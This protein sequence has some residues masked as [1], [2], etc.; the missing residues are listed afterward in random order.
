[1][2]MR[3]TLRIIALVA[4]AVM[5]LPLPAAGQVFTKYIDNDCGC[6]IVVRG[7]V[8]QAAALEWLASIAGAASDTAAA[9]IVKTNGSRGLVRSSRGD[10]VYPTVP[11]RVLLRFQDNPTGR[12]IV[13]QGTTPQADAVKWL[14]EV[15]R[16]A[17]VDAVIPLIEKYRASGLVSANLSLRG[18]GTGKGGA[19]VVVAWG[20]LHRKY[21]P[22]RFAVTYRDP[23]TG[24]SLSARGGDTADVDAWLKQLAAVQNPGDLHKLVEANSSKGLVTARMPANDIAVVAFL[25]E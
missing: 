7:A 23:P 13:A 3:A 5:A 4:P 24:R 17:D 16:A 22:P 9:A 19:E 18:A 10:T 12:E 1:M 6:S 11:S 2:S 20:D 15:S 14:Q 25:D 21:Q 8:R